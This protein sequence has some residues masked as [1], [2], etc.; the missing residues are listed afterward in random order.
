M[1][2]PMTITACP[3]WLPNPPYFSLAGS[4]LRKNRQA[5]GILAL[6]S[7]DTLVRKV[8]VNHHNNKQSASP[9]SQKPPLRPAAPNKQG[10]DKEAK[11]G[12]QFAQ[13]ALG[14]YIRFSGGLQLRIG[15]VCERVDP[16][17][18]ISIRAVKP[19]RVANSGLIHH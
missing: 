17:P 9:A 8:P 19:A 2:I 4:K 13:V 14:H 7:A 11:I 16:K 5:A 15:N 10:L 1:T 3:H 18:S 12:D 6:W